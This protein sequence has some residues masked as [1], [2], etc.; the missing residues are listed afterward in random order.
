MFDDVF[1]VVFFG[2][3][4]WVVVVLTTCGGLHPKVDQI[5]GKKKRRL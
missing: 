1:G 4:V 5:F 2:D 3:D